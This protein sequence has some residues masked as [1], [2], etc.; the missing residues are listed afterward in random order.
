MF[1]EHRMPPSLDA[2][3]AALVLRGVESS[4]NRNFAIHAT[5]DGATARRRA[6][7]LRSMLRQIAGAFGPARDVKVVAA[8]EDVT[9]T[10]SLA[11]VALVREARLS[12]VDLAILRVA[13]VERGTRL[14]P[15]ALIARDEDRARVSALLEEFARARNAQIESH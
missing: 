6:Q 9:I 14:L 7:R 8:G 2:L 1:R 5:R 15:A 13:L 4:R 12:A 3:T 11:R 10:F